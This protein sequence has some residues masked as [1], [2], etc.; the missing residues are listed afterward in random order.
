MTSGAQLPSGRRRPL[1][2]EDVISGSPAFDSF[3]GKRV[4]VVT[5]SG[6]RYECTVASYDYSSNMLVEAARRV[7]DDPETPGGLTYIDEGVLVL[8]GDDVAMIGEVG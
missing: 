8:K 7:L 3:V 2:Y 5:A 6:A 1:A 4:T